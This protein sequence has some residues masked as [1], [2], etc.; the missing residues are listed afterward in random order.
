MLYFKKIGIEG[1]SLPNW[2][3]IPLITN[4]KNGNEIKLISDCPHM[5][6][7]FKKENFQLICW[8]WVPGPGPGDFNLDFNDENELIEFILSYYFGSNK[9]FA[10]RLEHELSK[11]NS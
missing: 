5:W 3:S 8:D 9:Y 11:N 2:N 6:L 7:W 1:N 10:Q 4:D